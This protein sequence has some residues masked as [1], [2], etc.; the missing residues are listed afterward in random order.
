MPPLQEGSF[1]SRLR[2]QRGATLIG[3]ALAVSVG[4][5]FLTGL[6]SHLQQH[7]V[8][9]LPIPALP[10]WLYRFSQGL[11]V[12]SGL[13]AIPLLL[14]KL[15]T[16]YP[17]LFQWPPVAG[18]V[19]AVERLLIFV[20][21]AG[22]IFQL[23]T[24][25]LNTTQWYPW[26]FPFV[27]THYA[28]AFIILGALLLHVGFKY[29]TIRRALRTDLAHSAPITNRPEPEEDFGHGA[30]DDT[31]DTESR[32][33]PE[34][35]PSPVGGLSRRGL[36]ITGGVAVGAVTV[37][38]IG[39]TVSPLQDIAALAPRI[40]DI[41]PQQ[42]PVNRTAQAAGIDLLS[43]ERE[44]AL[45]LLGPD[46]EVSLS[47]TEL[48]ELPQQDVQLP[49]SCVEGWSASALWGGVRIKDLAALV[50]GG[51]GSTVRVASIEQNWPY[52]RSELQPQFVGSDLTLLAL[53]I[54]GEVLDADHGYPARII[55]PNRPGV[56]QTKWVQRLE[57]V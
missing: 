20:L 12:A 13:A 9:W 25:T 17:R 11:H 23:A 24:G 40:P 57:V 51:E 16:V 44:Y 3:I 7:P 42:V 35:A 8:E 36:L 46:G 50:G 19:N 54:N 53:R 22:M 41:G 48:G 31:D 28:F 27:P 32:T 49:I 45:Q 2:T 29:W 55:A 56:L 33:P 26:Q 4:L 5:C 43:V 39:Q 15:W 10:T 21:V 14:V 6:Y 1:S 30:D 37:T 34:S 47:L 18:V 52:A 38:T